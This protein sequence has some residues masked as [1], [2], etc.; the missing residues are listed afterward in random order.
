M[1][2]FKALS[3]IAIIVLVV[4]FGTLFWAQSVEVVT[5]TIDVVGDAVVTEVNH[6]VGGDEEDIDLGEYLVF[7]SRAVSDSGSDTAAN[8][9]VKMNT[10]YRALVGS[11]ELEEIATI[12]HGP[13]FGGSLTSY[14]FGQNILM[15]RYQTDREYDSSTRGP[16]S[17]EEL[18]GIMTLTGEVIEVGEEQW[19]RLRSENGRYQV[20]WDSPYDD[21]NTDL[22]V[23]DVKTG[24]VIVTIDEKGFF[25]GESRLE[26]EPFLI[27][28]DGAYMYVHEICGCEAPRNGL[29]EVNLETLA[30]VK[31]TDLIEFDSWSKVSIDPNSR[32]LISVQTE[33]EPA[34]DGPYYELFPPAVIQSLNLDTLETMTIL[35]DLTD[36]WDQPL[37]DPTGQGRFI[38]RKWGDENAQ[39]LVGFDTGEITDKNFLT[40]GWVLDWVGDWLVMHDFND[41]VTTLFN[42]DTHESVEI[43]I[44]DAD[45]HDYVGSID[46]K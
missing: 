42:V 41:N 31:L 30:I 36:A 24:E 28:D 15:H 1:N 38:V 37:L 33:S 20:A 3:L 14:V 29:W 21:I 19:G 6:L 18:D 13:E 8:D 27:D 9:D 39:Y 5:N 46:Y 44:K 22:V 17:G 32:M 45:S 34:A 4:G 12:E 2:S 10:F 23:T 7:Q 16:T 11:S 40:E 26:Y 43:N 25:D 35:T